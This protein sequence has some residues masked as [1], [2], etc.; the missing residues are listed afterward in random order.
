MTESSFISGYQQQADNYLLIT[1]QKTTMARI[2][3][4]KEE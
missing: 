3:K 2:D 1:C 4:G